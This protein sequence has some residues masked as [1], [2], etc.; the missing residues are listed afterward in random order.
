MSHAKDERVLLVE[1]EEEARVLPERML[2]ESG[3]HVFAARNAKEAF[4][5]FERRNG[6]FRILLTDVALRHEN[7]TKVVDR[8]LAKQAE[9]TKDRRTIEER[10]YG[11]LQ[12][13]YVLPE[14]L[15]AFRECV[16]GVNLQMLLLTLITELTEL[17]NGHNET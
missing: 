16:G 10:T 17:N 15:K 5:V 4:D 1:N 14:L 11:F 3:Y 6:D 13:P 9:E 8:L 7:G 2:R 12:K